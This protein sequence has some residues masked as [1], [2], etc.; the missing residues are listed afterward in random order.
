MTES[1][2]RNPKSFNFVAYCSNLLGIYVKSYV[3][4]HSTDLG[5]Q[6]IEALIEFV[7]GPCRLNQITL[8]E[9]KVIDCGRDLL[10]QGSI[11]QDE[12]EKKGFDGHERKQL[13]DTLKMNS[14]KLLLSILEGPVD[15]DIYEKVSA[16]LGDFQIVIK[17]METLYKEFVTETL[18]L[19]ESAKTS[20]VQSALRS[21]TL[22]GNIS[23]GFDIY[24]LLNQLGEVIENDK[25]KLENFEATESYKFYKKN[26][27]KI[28]VNIDGDIQ[29]VF[30]IIQP[31]CWFLTAKSKA[32]FE[33]T[34]NRSSQQDKILGLI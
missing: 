16:S 8:V 10:A 13:L 30:F 1:G 23:E 31:K 12:L 32:I 4:R 29:L 15:E 3:N 6:L 20:T 9:T 11:S 21:E 14:V 27:G 17:R 22:D 33:E 19:P 2:V 7:Q 34:V 25:K 28:E 5:N 24:S 26:S 18:E